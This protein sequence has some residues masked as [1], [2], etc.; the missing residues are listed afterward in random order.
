MSEGKARQEISEPSREKYRNQNTEDLSNQILLL[1]LF[2]EL[3][4]GGTH[5]F[6]RDRGVEEAQA[7]T[8]TPP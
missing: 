6:G 8:T 2:K 3:K 7:R 4:M 1:L 5:R